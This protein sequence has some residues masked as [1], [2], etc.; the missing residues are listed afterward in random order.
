MAIGRFPR[1]GSLALVSAI[2]V[3]LIGAGAAP[4]LAA[5][6]CIVKNRTSGV[7]Y[8]RSTGDSLQTAMDDAVEETVL[9][10]RGRCVGS[11]TIERSLTIVGVATDRYPKATLDA[12]GGPSVVTI[13]AGAVSLERLKITGG[14]GTGTFESGGIYNGGGG[15]LVLVKSW[16]TGNRS[17]GSGGGIYSV[18]D[19]LRLRDSRVSGNRGGLGG[20]ISIAGT[21][22]LR[23]RSSVDHNF[24]G[25]GGGGIYGGKVEM[26]DASRVSDNV[27]FNNGGGILGS[28]VEMHDTARITHNQAGTVRGHGSAGGGVSYVGSLILEDSSRITMNV[29]LSEG[30]GVY[31]ATGTIEMSGDSRISRNHAPTGGGVH[32]FEGHLVMS[33]RAKVANNVARRD[34]GGIWDQDGFVTMTEESSIVRNI[35]QG[36]TPEAPDGIGGGIRACRTT[37]TGVV[38]GVNV[39]DNVPDD[40]GTCP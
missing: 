7:V 3:T 24:A 19:L 33:G 14:R 20:G 22:V 2:V 38:A 25:N 21:L 18:G 37:L 29:S 1:I 9:V 8:P 10:V 16:V 36:G 28:I 11:Y 34:G 17:E 23:G 31:L 32:S 39:A 6:P 5:G 26:Y 4:A 40:I 27:S 12:A 35:A 13:L 30:G 15:N